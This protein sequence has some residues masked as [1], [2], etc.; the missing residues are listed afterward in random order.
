LTAFVRISGALHPGEKFG[1][2]EFATTVTQRDD[3]PNRSAVLPVAMTPPCTTSNA[4]A[5]VARA[6]P[7]VPAGAGHGAVRA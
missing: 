3:I 6:H 4:V 1:T 7:R 5:A 2:T